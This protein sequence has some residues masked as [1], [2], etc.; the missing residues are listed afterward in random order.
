VARVQRGDRRAFD[1]LVLK[2]QNRVAAL[3][4]R[5]IR[6]PGRSGGPDPGGVIRAYRAISTFRGDSAFY[7]WLY[8]IAI[9]TAKN[10]LVALER[11]PPGSDVDPD[12]RSSST[13]G[14]PQGQHHA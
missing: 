14:S 9:N 8:R 5:Y 7:T 3:I 13:S 12:E 2:Y 10:Q 6:D 4:A 11:R 1:L